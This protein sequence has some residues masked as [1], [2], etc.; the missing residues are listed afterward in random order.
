MMD[1]I[2][3]IQTAF[4]VQHGFTEHPDKPGL[5]HHVPDGEYPMTIYGKVDNV[6]IVDGRINCCN[7]DK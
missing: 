7:F 3:K 1:Y 2:R 6:R 5:P 4:I